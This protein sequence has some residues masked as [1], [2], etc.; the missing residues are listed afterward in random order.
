MEQKID[1]R[2]FGNPSFEEYKSMAKDASLSVFEKIGFPDSYRDGKEQAIM[3]DILRKLGADRPSAGKTFVDI[4]CGCSDL[5]RLI[6]EH[7]E[8]NHIHL[9]QIDCQEMLDL[10]PAKYSRKIS[11]MFPGEVSELLEEMAGKVDFILA[12]SNLQ[13]G[14]VSNSIYHFIDAALTMLSPGGKALFGDIPNVSKRK[15]F[16]SSETGI[17]SHRKFMNTSEPP[18]VKAFVPEPEHLDDGVLMGLMQRYRNFGFEA[19]LLPQ[20]E[21]LPLATRRED[22]LICKL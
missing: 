7:C 17:E 4:G 9:V 5:P 15:R 6:M 20:S 14:F 11:G 3:N 8:V 12:Y 16:F 1:F 19:Y 2:K 18:V 10:L 21:E 22:L 13:T